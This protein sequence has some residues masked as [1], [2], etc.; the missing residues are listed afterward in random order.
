MLL[1]LTPFIAHLTKE[2]RSY[3][4]EK[5]NA[6]LQAIEEPMRNA[7]A[8]INWLKCRMTFGMLK[9]EKAVE[10]SKDKN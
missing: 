4:V 8:K 10:E 5:L 1:D 2:A 6:K 9:V 3:I 7:R